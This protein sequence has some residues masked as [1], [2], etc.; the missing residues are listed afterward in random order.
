M[1]AEGSIGKKRLEFMKRQIRLVISNC[2]EC[3]FLSKIEGVNSYH[4]VCSFNKLTSLS[5][6]SGVLAFEIKE[7]FKDKCKLYIVR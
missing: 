1:D 5:D 3:P 4:Y 2:Y 6:K 7:W